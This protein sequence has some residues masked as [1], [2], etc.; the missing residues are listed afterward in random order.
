MPETPP[1]IAR[2]IACLEQQRDCF[3]QLLEVSRRQKKAIDEENDPALTQAMQDK[4]PLLETL[5]SL[6]DEMQ[7]VLKNLSEAEREL[8]V[9]HGQTV[10]DEAAEA[11]KQL[12]AMEDASAEIIRTKKEETFEQMKIFQEHKKGLK[13]YED[14]GGGKSSRFTQ[15][16]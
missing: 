10:K 9:Q 2:M 3:R 8:M 14:K 15:E 5:Q 16:G 1:P 12:I 7:P 11:L 13:G 4:N 6:D